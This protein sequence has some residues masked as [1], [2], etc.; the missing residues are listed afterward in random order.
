VGR[1]HR[2]SVIFL[3]VWVWMGKFSSCSNLLYCMHTDCLCL[4]KQV[5]D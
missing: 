5:L 4:G 3:S 1:L 2:E